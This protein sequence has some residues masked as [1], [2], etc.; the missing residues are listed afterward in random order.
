MLAIASRS[1]GYLPFGFAY[2]FV[3]AS[4]STSC[5]TDNDRNLRLIGG[6]LVLLR[7]QLPSFVQQPGLAVRSR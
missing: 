3:A 4:A 2:A 1:D 7:L 6:L 5:P